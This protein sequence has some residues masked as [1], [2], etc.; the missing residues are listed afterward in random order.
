MSSNLLSEI[1]SK[2]IVLY[3][4]WQYFKS[5]KIRNSQSNMYQFPWNY[6]SVGQCVRGLHRVTT[7][8]EA[9]LLEKVLTHLNFKDQMT[10]DILISWSDISLWFLP[11]IKCRANILYIL[12]HGVPR[13]CIIILA[14][15]LNFLL[16][17][18]WEFYPELVSLQ[19]IL[20]FYFCNYVIPFS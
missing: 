10:L 7:C 13:Q 16:H 8:D 1:I 11:W 4:T 9:V 2:I 12:A 3:I 20:G 14:V 5:T 15:E 17:I 18:I 19:P 6:G